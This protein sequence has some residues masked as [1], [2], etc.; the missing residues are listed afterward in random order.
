MWCCLNDSFISVVQSRDDPNSLLVRARRKKHLTRH[1]PGH[2]IISTPTADYPYRVLVSRETFATV[3]V[4]AIAGI[5]YDNFKNSV[6]DADLHSFY[7]SV[8]YRGRQL[9]T[10]RRLPAFSLEE[11]DA[12]RLGL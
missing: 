11:D 3:M 9:E 4:K 8:W 6:K 1:F 7:L 10:P 12:P 2:K 5:T